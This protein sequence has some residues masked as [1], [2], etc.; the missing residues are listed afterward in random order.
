M[1]HGDVRKTSDDVL[2]FRVAALHRGSV[3]FWRKISLPMIIRSKFYFRLCQLSFYS[4]W[5]TSSPCI[6]RSRKSWDPVKDMASR[7]TVFRHVRPSTH[8]L[9]P[10]VSPDNKDILSLSSTCLKHSRD[11]IQDMGMDI[12][13]PYLEDIRLAVSTPCMRHQHH[14][15][16]SPSFDR[17]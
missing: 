2:I 5:I 17:L 3:M 11:F 15:L 8:Q 10:L 6:L 7:L 16:V 14:R 13:P 9:Q 4:R 12:N 1:Q